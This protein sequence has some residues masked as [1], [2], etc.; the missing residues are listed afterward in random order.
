MRPFTLA[1][2]YRRATVMVER[3]GL[4]PAVHACLH[5]ATG[6]PRA[7][8]ARALLVALATHAIR[9]GDIH[10]TKVLATLAELPP[11]ARHQLGL[12][13]DADTYRMLWH[14]FTRLVQAIE[15]GTL[16][17]PHNH[18]DVDTRTG[19]IPPCAADCPHQVISLSVFTGRLLASSLPDSLGLT[20]AAAIDSTDYETWARRRSWA[21]TPDIDPDH[22]PV[23]DTVKPPTR[24]TRSRPVPNEPGWPRTGADGRAQ[25]TA[26]PDARE[27]YRSGT[28]GRPGNV[29][30]GYDLHLAVNARAVNGPEVPFVF[31]GMH[32]APAGTHKGEAGI[33]LLDQIRAH[34]QV[35]EVAAD[36]GYSYC[37]PTRWA[38]PLRT[39]GIEPVIDL[40][41]KQRGTRP[42]PIPGTVIVDGGLFTD[43]LPASWRALP[44]YTLGMPREKKQALRARYDARAAYAFTPHTRRDKDGYQRLKGPAL[45]A[46]LRCP[47]HPR[48]RRLPHYIPLATCRPG[49]DCACGK[50]L[51]LP[52]DVSPWTQQRTLWGTT[53]WATDYGRRNAIESGNA[54]AKTHRLHL[55]R[56]FTRVMGTPKNTLLLTFSLAGLN[57]VILRD[58]H[59]KRR[60][61]DPWAAQL[62]EPEPVV[63]LSEDRK[64]RARRRTATLATLT[65]GTPPS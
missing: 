59:A 39:R 23:D 31:T 34:Q 25:H 4:L 20:G 65:S 27:G 9:Q 24:T 55:D 38:H 62:D 56:G 57:H 43:A 1:Q 51:T 35:S 52:P 21:R 58:W 36:R 29:F 8:T 32:L 40:H 64:T 12:A 19:E 61:R 63:L 22:L 10:L 6:A 46:R 28:N 54:E 42:G 3:S 17:T 44:G 5:A 13:R 50:T 47:N 30:C 11:S 33:A 53:G 7:F 26:D 16:A 18:L 41:P 2:A 48:S 60:H 14:A 15:D 49:A 45:A 37:T